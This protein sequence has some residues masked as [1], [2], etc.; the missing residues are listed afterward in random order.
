[1]SAGAILPADRRPWTNDEDEA[2]RLLV[3]EHGT[4]RWSLIAD[5]LRERHSITHRTGKQCR[6]RWHNHLDP[7]VN[8]QPW[9]DEEE[10][11]IFEAHKKYGN[12]WAEIAK[13]LPGR[14]D[15]SIKNHFYSTLRRNMRRINREI[16]TPPTQ[17]FRPDQLALPPD[18]AKYDIY[19]ALSNLT[20][21]NYST[22]CHF[23]DDHAQ[24]YEMEKYFESLNQI[25]APPGVNQISAP[26]GVID[27]DSIEA[28]HA[29][30]MNFK[31]FD[32]PGGHSKNADRHLSLVLRL[33][34]NP[35]V[36]LTQ[37][38]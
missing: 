10:R 2:I 12:K 7:H 9:S 16:S 33:L 37:E 22:N 4:K 18:F 23:Q 30:Q 26:P 35:P 29:N 19:T 20:N 36:V 11:I 6:E 32:T 3:F 31:N 13:L 38:T 8:K 5:L 25:S 17:H 1:M 28:F 34:C 15:N 14:T 21:M 24:R 27:T